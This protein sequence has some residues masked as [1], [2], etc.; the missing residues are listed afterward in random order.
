MADR[1]VIHGTVI[2]GTVIHTMIRDGR[3]GAGALRPDRFDHVVDVDL[4]GLGEIERELDALA[5]SERALEAEQHEVRRLRLENDGLP[6][7]YL[8]PALH[9]THRH[10]TVLHEH[11]MQLG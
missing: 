1:T 5:L 6:G 10:D 9:R 11:L 8:G 2:H 4:S 7:L 3:T